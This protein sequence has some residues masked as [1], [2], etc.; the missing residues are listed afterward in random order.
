MNS[1]EDDG[2]VLPAVK[3]KT[4]HASSVVVV[5]GWLLPSYSPPLLGWWIRDTT[6]GIALFWHRKPIFIHQLSKVIAVKIEMQPALKK[7]KGLIGEA[8]TSIERCLDEISDRQEEESPL[9]ETIAERKCF[10][11]IQ[12]IGKHLS[13]AAECLPPTVEECPE[14][15]IPLSSS[16]SNSSSSSSSSN[17]NEMM[18]CTS[19]S[20]HAS[21]NTGRV[22]AVAPMMDCGSSTPWQNSPAVQNNNVSSASLSAQMCGAS[23]NPS[24]VATV[25]PATHSARLPITPLPV[26]NLPGLYDPDE[27]L[28]KRFERPVEESTPQSDLPKWLQASKGYWSVLRERKKLQKLPMIPLE[29]PTIQPAAA[30]GFEAWTTIPRYCAECVITTPDVGVPHEDIDLSSDRMYVSFFL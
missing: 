18:T 5:A 27:Q 28:L 6:A 19:T 29:L 17:N 30:T 26:K 20:A 24:T 7:V 1:S 9:K 21:M 22:P 13:A 12:K 4:T 10:W 25:P 14:S 16:S 11:K 15:G 8:Q 23:P 3:N 2:F